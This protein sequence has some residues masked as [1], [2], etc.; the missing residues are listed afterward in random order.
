[1]LGKYL[2]QIQVLCN[3]LLSCVLIK[4]IIVINKQVRKTLCNFL[5]THRG[6]NDEHPNRKLKLKY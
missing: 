2:V 3:Y 1:M 5:D 4:R 6:D